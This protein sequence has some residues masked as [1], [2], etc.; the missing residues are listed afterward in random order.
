MTHS[1]FDCIG[2][3]VSNE[4]DLRKMV[5]K[6]SKQLEPFPGK[7]YK[8]FSFALYEE[9]SGI[10][11]YYTLKGTDISTINPHFKGKTKARLKLYEWFIT[12]EGDSLIEAE[13]AEADEPVPML[14]SMPDYFLQLE[15]DLGEL[16]DI[17]ITAFAEA[18]EVFDNEEEFSEAATVESEDGE[19]LNFDKDFF[20]PEGMFNEEN[21]EARALFAATVKEKTEYTNKLT[22]K[23]FFVLRASG[24]FDTDIVLTREMG[25]NVKVGQI[26]QGQFWLSGKPV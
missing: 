5:K 22:G 2:F 4:N 16:A 8:D 9:Q 17:Q 19:P 21:P 3:S 12:E 7:D 13:T 10:Q 6:M 26:I 15:E 11:I 25:E 23:N 18:L 14:F 20:I 24:M 1:H